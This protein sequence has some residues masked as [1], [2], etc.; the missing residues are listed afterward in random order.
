MTDEQLIENV[1][2]L[3]C[4]LY[5]AMIEATGKRIDL[6]ER[7]LEC[8]HAQEYEANIENFIGIKGIRITYSDFETG[9]DCDIWVKFQSNLVL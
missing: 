9:N 4:C 6:L 2:F 3:M 8:V 5:A 7:A 1:N